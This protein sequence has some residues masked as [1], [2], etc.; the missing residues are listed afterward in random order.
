LSSKGTIG[1]Q[2]QFAILSGLVCG[3]KEEKG[4]KE[5]QQNT[6]NVDNMADLENQGF[7]TEWEEWEV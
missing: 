4:G 5:Y 6:A 3:E 2:P 1:R 7:L